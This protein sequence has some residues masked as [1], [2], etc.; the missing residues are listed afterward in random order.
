MVSGSSTCPEFSRPC[1]RSSPE[2][3]HA[4]RTAALTL[5]SSFCRLR[6]E[7]ARHQVLFLTWRDTKAAALAAADCSSYKSLLHVLPE[8][9]ITSGKPCRTLPPSGKSVWH[10]TR[11]RYEIEQSRSTSNGVTQILLHIVNL[12]IIGYWVVLALDSHI[13]NKLNSQIRTRVLTGYFF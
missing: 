6:T 1:C 3:L 5:G 11:G 8:V 13:K 7:I 2:A 9:Y 10:Y 12:A 4:L